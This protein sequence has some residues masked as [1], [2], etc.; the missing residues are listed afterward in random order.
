MNKSVVK[1]SKN[2]Y[3]VATKKNEVFRVE[4]RKQVFLVRKK[5]QKNIRFRQKQNIQI[6]FKNRL[7]KLLEF[8]IT[9]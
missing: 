7:I 8:V 9:V 3:F 4:Q 2:T 5:I 1:N 6:W